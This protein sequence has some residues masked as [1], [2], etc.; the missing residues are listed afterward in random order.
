MTPELA[1]EPGSGLH[2]VVI[3]IDEAH[4]LFGDSERRKAAAWRAAAHQAGPGAGDHPRDL[5]TQIP[6]KDELPTDI[7]RCIA[8]R[9]CLAVPI[10]SRTT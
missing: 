3:L 10:R 7:T 8:I 5:A 1:R 9:W 6:D 2:P 4:E